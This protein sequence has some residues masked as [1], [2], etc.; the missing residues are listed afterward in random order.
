[1][2]IKETIIKALQEDGLD[3]MT[4]CEL[5]TAKVAEL[6][7]LPPGRYRFYAGNLAI[8]VQRH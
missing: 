1:M 6:I 7:R 5:A 3:T 2:T 4:A 8:T